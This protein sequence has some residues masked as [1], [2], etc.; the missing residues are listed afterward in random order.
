MRTVISAVFK[1]QL[2]C[3]ETLSYALPLLFWYACAFL[4]SRTN[5]HILYH[6]SSS[7]LAEV[8]INYTPLIF[9][10]AIENTANIRCTL[11]R[12]TKTAEAVEHDGVVFPCPIVSV[13]RL[14][15]NTLSVPHFPVCFCKCHSHFPHFIPILW[16]GRNMDRILYPDV[17]FGLPWS[18]LTP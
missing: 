12:I 1:Q 9:D 8:R 18:C 2:F 5:I 3:S 16:A 10:N 14:V 11:D 6:C 13:K 15:S 4:R 7:S 17:A